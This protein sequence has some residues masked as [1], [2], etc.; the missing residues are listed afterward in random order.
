ML[1]VTSCISKKIS[2]QFFIILILA[3]ITNYPLLAQTA[4]IKSRVLDKTTDEPLIGANVI[5][6]GTSLGAASNIDG[7]F[8]ITD[9]PIGKQ[10][11]VISYI[12]YNSITVDLDVKTKDNKEVN[13]YLEPKTLEGE[14]VVVTAQAQGQLSAINQQLTSNTIVNIVARDRIK[15]L[16]D[17]NAAETI[18]RLPGVSIQRYGGEATKIEI[19]GLNPKYS[20]IT[21]NGVEV[22]ATSSEDRSVDLS[23]ISSNMLDGIVL[24]KSNTPDMDADVLGGTVDL[25][26]KEAPRNFQ[27]NVSAQGGYNKLQD[28]YGNYN[29]TA[30]ISNRFFDDQLG[31][32]VNVNTD[33]YNR[34]ADKFRDNWRNYNQSISTG[35]LILREEQV[36]RKR[37][38][39]SFLLDYII[40]EGK[41]TANAFFNQLNSKGLNHI[42]QVNTL[43][44]GYSTNRHIYQL[45]DYKST[46]NVYTSSLGIHQDFNWIRYDVSLS[47][48]GTANNTPDRRVAEFTQEQSALDPDYLPFTPPIDLV[49]FY[50]I[51]TIKTNLSAL[52]AYGTRTIEN[53]TSAKLN[54]AVPFSLGD[55]LSGYL[56]TGAKVRWVDRS[57]N[58]TQYGYSGLQY[59]SGA[60]NPV[61]RY[62]NQVFP[63]WGIQSI[64]EEYGLLNILPFLSNYTRSNFLNGDYPLGLIPNENMMLQMIEAL[65]AAPDSLNLWLPY[66]VGTFGYD[67]SGFERYEAAYLMG[68]FDIG[69]FLTFIPG[70]RWEEDFSSYNGQR[71]RVN[72]SGQTAEQPP[73]EFVRLN[74]IRKNKFWLPM[75]S[76]IV[77]PT[78]WL[79]IRL[80]GTR[81]LAR[82]D[83]LRYAPISYISG[84][85]KQVTAANYSLKPSRSTNF[86][87]GISIF[88]NEI[89]LFS[90]N[91]FYKKIE[92]LIFYSAIYYR[93]GITV[94][95]ALEIPPSWLAANPQINAYRNNPDPAQYS[96]F[97]IEWQTHFWYLPSVLS[98][99]VLNVNYT[100]IYSEMKLAYDSL[101]TRQV[102]TRRYYSLVPTDI[103]T[104]MPDQPAN[105]FNITIGYDIEGFSARLSYLYQTDKLTGI[106]YDGI[107]PTSRLSSYTGGY[108]R[109]DL[110]LQ[111][112][113]YENIQI[114]ANF[115]NLNNRHDQNFIGSDLS[116]PS[117]IEYYGFTMDLG[118]R[119][120]L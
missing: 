83:Y 71:Y 17:V 5:I 40:P 108:G 86:D 29:F 28:Y 60:T 73:S 59:G 25:R 74:K 94:D 81:T 23:L 9:I 101:I 119:F 1:F 110:T 22:P 16:P 46:V 62:L 19:R 80:A 58:Q 36:N 99:L 21:V 64:T 87:A 20:L 61:F 41:V 102:G 89:G 92:D 54:V 103:K 67:Y 90:V 63:E 14:T 49:K 27:L 117:Y 111:Q 15:E 113:L 8:I 55:Q 120:N 91:A 12:G 53:T 76:L 109:W 93:P 30:S 3:L 104:R 10:K 98:G 47:R 4:T 42:N 115:N 85:S 33:N 26:L 68:V 38:G 57:N 56:K 18:G 31:V 52:Y 11:L 106:G 107:Y 35:E 2:W 43:E 72:Q 6:E 70:V 112:K 77:K 118:V 45:E 44:N 24:K 13:Y 96:G 65:K 34:S 114:F 39:A 32:I 69:S 75:V 66:S 50:N 37:T 116:H 48:A 88:N 97:E 105:I 100:H 51:D 82:P 84:D 79:Q 7:R 78:D 95:P